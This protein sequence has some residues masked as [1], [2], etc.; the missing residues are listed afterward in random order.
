MTHQITVSI[1]P[2]SSRAPKGVEVYTHAGTGIAAAHHTDA[3][4]RLCRKLVALGA[5]GPA[6][7]RGEDG[8]LRLTVRAIEGLAKVILSENDRDGLR[9]RRHV[10]LLMASTPPVAA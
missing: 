3:L 7:V 10:P 1:K 9:W 8:R 4:P 5:F 2:P 6:E